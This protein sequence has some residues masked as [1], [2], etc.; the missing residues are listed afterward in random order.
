M[1]SHTTSL[2]IRLSRLDPSHLLVFCPAPTVRPL[3]GRNHFIADHRL[4]FGDTPT[5]IDFSDLGKLISRQL[6]DRIKPKA[7]V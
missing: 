7:A 6:L 5:F 1:Y 3:D 4:R 2:F